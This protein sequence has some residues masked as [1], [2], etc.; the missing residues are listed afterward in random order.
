[1]RKPAVNVFA[2]GRLAGVL[3]RS[4]R[5][6]DVILFTYEPDCP[7]DAAVS[8]TMDVGPDQYDSMG[9]LLPIFEMNLP[10]GILKERLRNDI[11]KTIPEFDDLDLLGI[12]GE[13]QIG[14]LRYSHNP[15]L[16]DDIPEQPVEEILN[17][18]GTEDLFENLMRRYARYSGVSGVQPK[19]LVRDELPQLQRLT[20]QGASHIVKTFDAREFPQ[21][22]ANEYLCTQGARAAGLPTTGIRIS[23]N[24]QILIVDR[25]DR[26]D[27]GEYLGIEDFCVLS[28]RRSHGRYDGSY[29]NIAKRIG[30]FVST[31][32]RQAAREQLFLMLA[33]A[34]A[35]E[36][37][38]AHLKNFSIL[39]D[40]PDDVVSLAPAYDLVCTRVYQP[41]DS[42]ALTLDKTKQFPER[43]TLVKY[44]RTS[45]NLTPRITE[46]LLDRAG[47]GASRALALAEAFEYG[48]NG[49]R[50]VKAFNNAINRGLDQS[51]ID[52]TKEIS[53]P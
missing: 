51:I 21:L 42:L 49:Q 2:G 47:D 33:Y 39:Y 30:Q 14:R 48:E 22:A 28:G 25:F 6:D 43:K 31:E 15:E 12:V 19:V 16:T 9:G 1:M 36:N 53:L 34:C 11:A 13:S 20:H 10:E 37:G 8:I 24:R 46:E 3:D 32:Y 50:F 18:S 35:I 4:T 41:H 44:A 52:H 38:D 45:L 17:Y 26:N 29:E 5:G 23:D 40:R 27:S 7:P